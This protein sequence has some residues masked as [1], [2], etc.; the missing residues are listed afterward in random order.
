MF[1]G[2]IQNVCSVKGLSRAGSTAALT[3]DLGSL[4]GLTKIGDSVAING[5]CLTVAKLAGPLVTFDLSGETLAKTTLGKL[6]P[7]SKVNVELA[8]RADDRF[9]G[10]FVLGHIDGIATIQQIEK[11]D[12]FATFTFA[13]T[14]D[15]LDLMVPKGSVAVD[16]I[17]LTIAELKPD[18]FTVAVIPQTLLKT[19]LGFAKITAQVNLETDIISRTVVRQLESM[20]LTKEK[21]TVDKLQQLGF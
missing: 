8:M 17:S 5:V 3:V 4:A 18:S 13:A 14:K 21:L 11:K 16:G 20:G 9:G 12:D 10:H 7:G 19:N 1:T 2:L 6:T 15:L